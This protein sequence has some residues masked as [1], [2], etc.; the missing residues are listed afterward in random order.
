[1]IGKSC[2]ICGKKHYESGARCANCVGSANRLKTACAVCGKLGENSYCPEHLPEEY[3]GKR[4]TTE[5]MKTQPWR[6]GYR[7]PNYHRERA[8]AL[9]RARGACERCGRSDLK[10]E[11]DHIVALSTAKDLDEVRALN[12]RDNLQVLC[13]MCH[14][15]KT[16]KT[17]R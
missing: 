6:R 17:K 4:S 1:M 15:S 16:R 13:V 12:R 8:G 3:G 9:K 14:R 5:R 2:R 11:V 7:D 10:L